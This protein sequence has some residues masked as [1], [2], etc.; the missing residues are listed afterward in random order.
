M[1]KKSRFLD[2][3]V[4]PFVIERN[5]TADEILSRMERISF[6]GRNLATAHRIWQ[7]MLADDVT[8][9]LGMAGA[10]SAGGLIMMTRT[11][12]KE[13]A[14]WRIRV[15]VLSLTLVEDSPTWERFQ[16][17]QRSGEP[18]VMARNF[19][20]IRDRAPLGL[21]KPADVA[22]A[23]AFLVSDS[24]RTITGTTLSPTGGL[25]LM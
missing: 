20:K 17:R 10:L 9:F 8:I 12:A 23:A 25:T 18:D 4:E 24:A 11:L 3:P 15:N 2:I 14:R 1:K 7:K 19:A 22:E 5:L 16:E 13:L 21:A 6:Q